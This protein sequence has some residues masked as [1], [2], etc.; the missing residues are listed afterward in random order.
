LPYKATYSFPSY[1]RN[2]FQYFG[3]IFTICNA[4]IALTDGN[5]LKEIVAQGKAFHEGDMRAKGIPTK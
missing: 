5:K 2:A 1:L 3:D 4:T